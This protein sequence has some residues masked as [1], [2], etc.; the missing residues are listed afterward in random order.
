VE[1]DLKTT[2][3]HLSV[4]WSRSLGKHEQVLISNQQ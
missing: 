4:S 1:L 2:K 3:A